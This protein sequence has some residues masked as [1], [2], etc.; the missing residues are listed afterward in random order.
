M[1]FAGNYAFKNSRPIEKWIKENNRWTSH[2]RTSY[3]FTQMIEIG[4][5]VTMV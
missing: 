1:R 3:R 4:F 5:I 2:L